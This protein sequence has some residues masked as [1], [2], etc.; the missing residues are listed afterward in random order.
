MP[1][2]D[3]VQIPKIDL[4]TLHAQLQ[5]LHA[6][7]QYHETWLLSLLRILIGLTN[8][9]GAAYA[10]RQDNQLILSSR[11]LSKQSLSWHSSLEE[12]LIEEMD[13]ACRMQE[14]QLK[15]LNEERHIW[16][17]SSPVTCQN[18]C[19]SMALVVVQ[20]QQPVEMFVV[21]LQLVAHFAALQTSQETLSIE[22]LPYQLLA[23]PTL[24]KAE[25]LLLEKLQPQLSCQHLFLG[26]LHGQHY[27][28]SRISDYE[29]IKRHADLTHAIEAF[30]NE[31]L[32]NGENYHV[33]TQQ[34]ASDSA[35]QILTLSQGQQISCLLLP[36]FYHDKIN[37][38]LVCI[39]QKIPAEQNILMLAKPLGTVLETLHRHNPSF[40][41]RWLYHWQGFWK[42]FFLI[43]IPTLCLIA[44]FI[45]VPYHIDG[46][47]LIH[48]T[49]RRFVTAP[50][51]GILKKTVHENGDI[52]EKNTVLAYLDER[53]IEWTLSGLIADKNRAQK[54]KDVAKAQRN[55]AN[56]QMAQLE[57]ERL[58]TQ[59]ALLQH[60]IANLAV[61][62]PINGII[63][64]G[65]LKRVEG[66]PVEKG[67]SLFE[68][69]PLDNMIV[70]LAIPA[71]D[72]VHVDENMLLTIYLNA[73]PYQKWQQ[74]LS[75][76]HPSATVQEG[77]AVFIVETAL[78]NEDKRL[79]PGMQGKGHIVAGEKPLGWV[80]FHK[81]WENMVRWWR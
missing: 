4:L 68:I 15:S 64:S 72:I 25:Q 29:N 79:R 33:Q 71:E 1:M 70:E 9:A 67:Q 53:E 11:I 73:F 43:A 12:L 13:T 74:P 30:M 65:D 50:F 18:Q 7:S 52:V 42:K 59:I 63:I 40:L 26:H 60:R 78:K 8:A 34:N 54:Q 23:Q 77:D 22:T 62:S 55:T 27:R 31:T 19:E 16:L 41:T 75:K 45:P 2:N 35:A 24:K 6:Q 80:L 20:G 56:A 47:V 69:A 36:N 51:E 28:L 14:V 46:K 10:I 21:I 57:I 17:I 32:I 66:S 48:P 3:T 5:Q 37:F 58:E 49:I 44:A 39:W 38:A 76:I 81:V 61:K